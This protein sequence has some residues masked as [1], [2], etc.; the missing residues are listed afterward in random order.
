[1]SRMSV[2]HVLARANADMVT[3][4]LDVTGALASLLAGTLEALPADAAAVLVDVDGHLEVLAATSHRAEELEGYQAQ[5]DQGPCLDAIRSGRVDEACGR[6]LLVGRWPVTGPT[7]V[8][9]GFSAVAAVPLQ[10]QGATF[11]ALNVFR[12]EPVGFGDDLRDCRALG[13]ALTLVLAA[14]DLGPD[15]VIEGLRVA[16][17]D[18]AVV[19]QAKGV[20]A[21]TRSLDMADAYD[22]LLALARGRSEPLGVS[23]RRLMDEA[24]SGGLDRE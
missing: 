2:S 4:D 5:V 11:G 14:R 15:H 8:R 12:N 1:M 19:E 20:L 16:L 9:A 3:A 18:R 21:E 24:R 10:W 23:A 22:A 13:D 17:R 6:E 7:I